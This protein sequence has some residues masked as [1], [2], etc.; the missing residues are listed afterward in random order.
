VAQATPL[1]RFLIEAAAEG[2]D[3]LTAEGRA[4]LAANAKPL[5]MALPDGA[6]KLQL[7]ADIASQVQLGTHELQ[8]LWGL[9]PA[10]KLPRSALRDESRGSA[11]PPRARTLPGRTPPAGRADHALRLVLGDSA[12]WDSLSH[13]DH[14]V[15]CSLPAPHGPLFRWLDSQVH[16]HG[17]QPWGSLREG[18]RGVEG[19]EAA[20]RLMS[21]REVMATEPAELE[22]ELR[23]LLNGLIVERLKAQETEALAAAPADPSAHERY[24]ALQARR[25][26]LE[27]Q[28]V[29]GRPAS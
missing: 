11:L 15:L 5:W 8:A 26:A 24:R 12:A 27:T 22:S 9:A 10:R 7:L 16:E 20:L 29:P 6:L 21:A 17:A 19:E 25:R 2:C 18:L 1:S 28:L 4:H 14:E 13:E 3:L 23:A